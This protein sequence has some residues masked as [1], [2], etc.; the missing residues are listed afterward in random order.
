MI[1]GFDLILPSLSWAGFEFLGS[2][3]SSLTDLLETLIPNEKLRRIRPIAPVSRQKQ[4]LVVEPL[5][6]VP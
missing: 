2:P 1:F 6:T 5:E 4:A 3:K